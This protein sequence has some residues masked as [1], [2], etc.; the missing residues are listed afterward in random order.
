LM[1]NL[2]D[3]NADKNATDPISVVFRDGKSS[4]TDVSILHKDG[5][6]IPIVLHTIPICD[7]QGKVV[8]AAESFEKNQGA[9]DWARRQAGLADFGCLD[10]VTGAPS[11]SFMETQLRENLITF[12]EHHIPFGV[13]LIQIDH[14][15]VIRST[16]GPAVMP[17]ILRVVAQTLE[18][19]LRPNDLLGCWSEKLFLAI[20]MECK[21][22]EVSRVGERG[23]NMVGQ[24]EIEWWGDVFSVTCSFGGAGSRMGDTTD[25]LIERAARSLQGSVDQG[26]N[27]VTTLE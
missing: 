23:R 7:R 10:E 19:C 12:A 5:Y 17:T 2:N 11:Q 16:C 27:C 15:D 8:G 20:L 9:S 26:G 18:N 4:T 22:S 14:M 25:L 24:S 6:R 3:P 1:V 13:M 21:E